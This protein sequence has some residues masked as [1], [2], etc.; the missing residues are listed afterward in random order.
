MSTSYHPPHNYRV[1]APDQLR[2]FPKALGISDYWMPRTIAL[3]TQGKPG[4]LALVGDPP[5][6]SSQHDSSG[7]GVGTFH[8]DMTT[9]TSQGWGGGIVRYIQ[10]GKPCV[11]KPAEPKEGTFNLVV[12]IT[13]EDATEIRISEREHIEDFQRAWECSFGLVAGLAPKCSAEST[14]GAIRALVTRLIEMGAAYVIPADPG[15]LANWGPRVL[16]VYKALCA[17]SYKRDDKGHHSPIEYRFTVHEKTITVRFAFGPRHSSEEFVI[18][19][20][21]S[22]VFTAASYEEYLQAKKAAVSQ[23]PVVAVA[24]LKVGTVVVWSDVVADGR[25]FEDYPL[26][27]SIAEQ[28]VYA[29]PDLETERWVVDMPAINGRLHFEQGEVVAVADT[30]TW[31]KIDFRDHDSD[32]TF[33]WVSPKVAELNLPGGY[34]YVWLRHHLLKPKT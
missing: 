17:H 31:V 24:G 15:D 27:P 2:G 22:P 7:I 25:L 19:G 3:V 32:G 13:A 14:E 23:P 34:G 8:F 20:E 26:G 21:I 1:V 4:D 12:E 29:V 6:D 16:A 5:Y 10:S 30:H 33:S 9:R 18:P 11:W 28:T